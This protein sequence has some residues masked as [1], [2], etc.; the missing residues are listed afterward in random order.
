MVAYAESL[1][2]AIIFA[3][4]GDL[5]P[6]TLRVGARLWSKIIVLSGSRDVVRRRA[7]W[8]E[9]ALALCQALPSWMLRERMSFLG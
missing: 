5:V 6:L 2:A 7:P 8:T 4:F 9:T 1:D 3:P